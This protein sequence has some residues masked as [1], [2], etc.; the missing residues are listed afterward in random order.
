M[1]LL[2]STLTFS[3]ITFVSRLAGYVRDMIQA[4]L[5]GRS[6]AMD[7]FLIAYRIPN[8]LRRIFA[9]GSFQQA[10]VPVFTEIKRK[11]DPRELRA[12]LDP[13]GGCAGRGG[14]VRHRP[15]HAGGADAHRPVRAGNDHRAGEV[16][17]DQ[18]DVAHHVSLSRVHFAHRAGGGPC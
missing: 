2:R 9:E 8:F 17:A 1:K 16:R 15:G 13:R 3:A 10:F 14:A 6:L 12:L 7:A 5:F 11:G 4:R 18:L